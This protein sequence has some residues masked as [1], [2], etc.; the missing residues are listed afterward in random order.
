R[1]S[2]SS[3]ASRILVVTESVIA[4]SL[5]SLSIRPIQGK[6]DVK[7]R[8]GFAAARRFAPA[9]TP[10]GLIRWWEGLLARGLPI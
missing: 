6:Q 1:M 2:L 8:A 9:A 7:A 3:S 5:P 4:P 10:V